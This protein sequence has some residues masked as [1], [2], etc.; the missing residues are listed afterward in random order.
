MEHEIKLISPNELEDKKLIIQHMK[1][2][3][4][5]TH[6]FNLP[7]KFI[8]DLD[9]IR[10]ATKIYPGT[11][12]AASDFRKNDKALILEL[13]EIDTKVLNHIEAH[14]KDDLE[15]VYKA[16]FLSKDKTSI[17]YDIKTNTSDRIN[18]L[19]FDVVD[20]KE[21]DKRLIK[22][23]EMERNGFI[24]TNMDFDKQLEAYNLSQELRKS[25]KPSFNTPK[26]I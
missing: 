23:L 1:L 10:E 9:I 12:S 25:D 5:V 3:G 6:L 14:L 2:N 26:K 8:D 7:K 18:T 24:L 17:A 16:F 15:V 13:L 21:F 20:M 11:I 4:L 19:L 22:C